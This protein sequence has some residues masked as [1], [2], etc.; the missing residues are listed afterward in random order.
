MITPPSFSSP[1]EPSD[2]HIHINIASILQ[3]QCR[4][5]STSLKKRDEEESG[6]EEEETQQ[7]LGNGQMF[8]L[9]ICGVEEYCKNHKRKGTLGARKK[10]RHTANDQKEGKKNL[11]R[12]TDNETTTS[13]TLSVNGALG[14]KYYTLNGIRNLNLKGLISGS[15]DPWGK[16]AKATRNTTEQIRNPDAGLLKAS[17][18][19]QLMSESR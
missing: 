12:G 3:P 1:F 2:P 8:P 15:W 16:T 17:A 14:P 5:L 11:S 6:A 9:I 19:Y 18:S 10:N 7:Q 13:R 4:H